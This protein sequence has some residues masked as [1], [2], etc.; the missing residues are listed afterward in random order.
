MATKK[1]S[2]AAAD[3]TAAT[4]EPAPGADPKSALSAACGR[5]QTYLRE[6]TNQ[7]RANAIPLKGGAVLVTVPGVG[8]VVID[9]EHLP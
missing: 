8:L 3:T 5:F 4:P 6:Q 2:K 1:S 7:P 9:G